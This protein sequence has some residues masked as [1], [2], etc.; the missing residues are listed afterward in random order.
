MGLF[1][2]I[3]KSFVPIVGLVGNYCSYTDS[4]NDFWASAS[5]V[6]L[7]GAERNGQCYILFRVCPGL[8][9]CPPN[10][11]KL[12][13]AKHVWFYFGSIDRLT[14]S[15][16]H[17]FELFKDSKRSY[18]LW[19]FNQEKSFEEL[20]KIQILIDDWPLISDPTSKPTNHLWGF[21]FV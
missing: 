19:A 21:G 1:Y 12:A 10:H 4:A 17:R 20:R 3:T 2:Q 11:Y 13:E 7:S 5:S 14:V 8:I 6:T 15:F 16:L 9:P 18:D